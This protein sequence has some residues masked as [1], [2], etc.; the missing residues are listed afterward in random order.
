M[1]VGFSVSGLPVPTGSE[2]QLCGETCYF[3]ETATKPF[4]ETPYASGFHPC[5]RL[6]VLYRT[7]TLGSCKL[8]GLDPN[9]YLRD[10]FDKLANGWKSSQLEELLPKQWLASRDPPVK[11]AA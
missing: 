11:L 8:L 4:P 6:G 5:Q 9:A 2:V 7:D 3:H 1:G 10:V